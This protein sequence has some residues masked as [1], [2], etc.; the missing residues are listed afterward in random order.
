MRRKSTGSAE[1]DCCGESVAVRHSSPENDGRK[2]SFTSA[3][4][5]VTRYSDT[6]DRR[7][8]EKSMIPA[9]LISNGSAIPRSQESLKKPWSLGLDHNMSKMPDSRGRWRSR[10]QSPWS[11]SL[12]TVSTTF[13]SIFLVSSIIHSFLTRQVD[14]KG[15]DMC[16]TR[17]MIY[18]EFVDFDTEHTRFASKYS[19]HLIRE[20]GFD[21]DPKVYQLHDLIML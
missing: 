1:E 15:C 6:L 14:S 3:K 9:Q 10:M 2:R 19:L 21:E 17:E 8:V 16:Y 13:L 4:Y 5:D 12:L 11:C 7:K 20:Q 18:F